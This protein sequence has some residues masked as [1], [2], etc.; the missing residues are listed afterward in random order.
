MEA[1]GK[2]HHILLLLALLTAVG[3]A[4]PHLSFAA[5]VPVSSGQRVGNNNGGF[6]RS[7]PRPAS[8][9]SSTPS[10]PKK[11]RFVVVKERSEEQVSV[12][13]RQTI[14]VPPAE[15]K[16]SST[17]KIYIP[18]RW[19]ETEDGVLVLEPGHWVESKAEY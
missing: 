2:K 9:P 15:P 13:I 14:V 1:N 4:L 18:P 16:K 17:N 8:S 5:S 11:Q 3:L 12:S 6:F 10:S 7:Q 19:V